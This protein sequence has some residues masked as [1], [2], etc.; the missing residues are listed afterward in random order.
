MVT[1]STWRSSAICLTLSLGDEPDQ[2]LLALVQPL[3]LTHDNPLDLGVQ[4]LR[5]VPY[6]PQVLEHMGVRTSLDQIVD[7]AG[8][9]RGDNGLFGFVRGQVDHLD[10][11][12]AREDR[13]GCPDARGGVLH[14]DVHQD[15]VDGNRVA[16]GRRLGSAGDLGRD[17]ERRVAGDDGRIVF[18][19][20]FHVLGNQDGALLTHGLSSLRWAAES[21]TRSPWGKSRTGC[22]PDGS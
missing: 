19:E 17:G 14:L 1:T 15:D 12:M 13:L 21:G 7:R 11:G 22:F 4:V 18:P 6:P 3:V 2:S 20:D 8:R 10:L 9:H 16:D 5:A